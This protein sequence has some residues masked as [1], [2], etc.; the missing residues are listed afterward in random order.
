MGGRAALA[1][2]G[3]IGGCAA[4]VLLGVVRDEVLLAAHAHHHAAGRRQLPRGLQIANS[5]SLKSP[6]Y[7]HV[8][9]A[10]RPHVLPRLSI[11]RGSTELYRDQQES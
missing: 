9:Y 2:V 10:C 7:L 1:G 3:G 4:H 11:H 6:L 5:K 8:Q